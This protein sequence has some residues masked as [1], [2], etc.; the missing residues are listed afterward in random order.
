M[1]TTT[2]KLPVAAMLTDTVS[3]TVS[4][5]A[6]DALRTAWD[7]EQ[8]QTAIVSN[9]SDNLD[10]ARATKKT[11][12]RD[13]YTSLAKLSADNAWTW[14]ECTKAADMLV[15]T[16]NDDAKQR[17]IR[18]FTNACLTA[19]HP[20]VCA[21]WEDLIEYSNEVYQHEDAAEL[22]GKQDH[23]IQKI[24][25]GLKK[26]AK[27]AFEPTTTVL[28]N[29]E[30]LIGTAKYKAAK[31]M[32]SLKKAIEILAEVQEIVPHGTVKIS[33]DGLSKL[34]TDSFTIGVQAA[35]KEK[36]ELAP[37]SSSPKTK[38]TPKTTPDTTPAPAPTGTPF[39]QSA[40]DEL[41]NNPLMQQ[42]AAMM[43]IKK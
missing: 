40:L 7:N 31:A 1:K 30:T 34:T 43:A 4:V 20:N 36:I 27:M 9:A 16:G 39:D 21:R 25:G 14:E 19:M 17:T 38:T 42:L 37:T 8:S 41:L 11:T 13:A 18:A 12:R 5:T 29:A 10:K 24:A 22:L 6:I 28:A 23:F 3:A 26:N 33:I 35:P 32:K 2:R 15:A